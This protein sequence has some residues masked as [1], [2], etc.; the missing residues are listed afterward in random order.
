MGHEA[1]NPS[2][3]DAKIE[4]HRS[5]ANAHHTKFTIAEH[6]TTARHPVT[7]LKRATGSYSEVISAGTTEDHTFTVHRYAFGSPAAKWDGNPGSAGFISVHDIVRVYGNIQSYTYS[8]EMS[9]KND[10]AV[11]LTAYIQWDYLQSSP[12]Y[13]I[14]HFIYLLINPDGSIKG[15][16]EA[17]D[18]PWKGQGSGITEENLLHPFLDKKEDRKVVLVN[19]SLELINELSDLS[20]KLK[21]G[22]LEFVNEGY[23]VISDEVSKPRGP[24]T[25]KIIAKGIEFRPL[26]KGKPVKV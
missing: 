17:P 15:G 4:T 24:V 20:R 11:S 13:E 12:P 22:F 26:V 9:A 18:P 2:E 10:A 7:V 19:P 1:I 5:D 23:F 6:D 16:W 25:E 8:W 21:K 3:V 14:E